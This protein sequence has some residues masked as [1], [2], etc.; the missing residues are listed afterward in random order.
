MR[1]KL[2]FL[3]LFFTTLT[4][5]ETVPSQEKNISSVTGQF[6]GAASSTMKEADITKLSEILN[7]SETGFPESWKN[8]TTGTQYEVI[9]I[10]NFDSA[11]GQ[12][13]RDYSIAA[14]TDTNKEKDYLTAC[15][16][17]NGRWKTQ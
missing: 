15:K 3:A 16:E 1:F 7:T 6:T 12:H 11:T 13:C 9:V 14:K 4:A 5:C 17:G 2:L 8:M 10:N